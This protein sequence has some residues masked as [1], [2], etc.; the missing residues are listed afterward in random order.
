MFNPSTNQPVLR[1]LSPLRI[2]SRKTTRSR[3]GSHSPTRQRELPCDVPL[4]KDLSPPPRPR[5]GVLLRSQ[6]G[7]GRI[8]SSTADADRLLEQELDDM[9]EKK[10]LTGKADEN[11]AKAKDAEAAGKE[12]RARPPSKQKGKTLLR[13]VRSLSPTPPGGLL[14]RTRTLSPKNKKKPNGSSSNK[15]DNNKEQVNKKETSTKKLIKHHSIRKKRNSNKRQALFQRQVGTNLRFCAGVHTAT[16]CGTTYAQEEDDP[17]ANANKEKW[18]ISE[19]RYDGNATFQTKG[20]EEIITGKSIQD[21]I[22]LFTA[23]P[24]QYIAMY[25]QHDMLEHPHKWPI[26]KH[27][28]TLIHR[29]G[30]IGWTPS[31][32]SKKGW[33]QCLIHQYEVLPPF[34][35]NILPKEFCDTYTDT[36]LSHIYN[37]QQ[38]LPQPALLPGRNMG[39]GNTD[40]P[41]LKIIGDIDPSDIHQGGHIGNC[42]MLSAICSLAEFDGSI[43]RLF[44]KTKQLDERPLDTPNMY[45]ITLWDL[46]TWTEVD[47]HVDERL[48]IAPGGKEL[49][50][51]RPRY[52]YGCLV[53]VLLQF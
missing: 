47:I 2:P 39:I 20:Q 34:K 33:L 16:T 29:E 15:E 9:E 48:C 3:S 8:T 31:N 46:T 12:S 51:S 42:W 13:R 40:T 4:R 25:Y 49:L 28:Y 35:D 52:V 41:N 38:L 36:I 21:G 37:G 17:F 7:P 1:G 32:V 18:K 6:T 14:N 26:N 44:R 23:N 30:T 27:K 53:Y 43:K 5:G 11:K 19:C 22:E 24:K 50:A 10:D 45:T